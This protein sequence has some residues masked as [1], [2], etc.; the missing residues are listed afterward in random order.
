L[1]V[2]AGESR[3]LKNPVAVAPDLPGSRRGATEDAESS[4]PV[5]GNEPF[6]PQPFHRRREKGIHRGESLGD[7]N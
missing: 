7:G 1:S 6:D 5:T 2:L 4:I 3:W